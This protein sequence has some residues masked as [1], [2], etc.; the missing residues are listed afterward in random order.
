MRVLFLLAKKQMNLK[1]QY[2]YNQSWMMS[3]DTANYKLE[4]ESWDLKG[5]HVGT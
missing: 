2:I 4:L 3:L 5:G 1:I